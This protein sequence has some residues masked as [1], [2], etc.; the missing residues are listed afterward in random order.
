MSREEFKKQFALKDL[1]IV[2]TI[3]MSIGG[4]TAMTSYRLEAV[5]TKMPSI[6]HLKEDAIRNE[7]KIAEIQSL[8]EEVIGLNMNLDDWSE[9][10]KVFVQNIIKQ[11][12]ETSKRIVVMEAKCSDKVDKREVNKWIVKMKRENVTMHIP[13]LGET[14]E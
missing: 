1:V 5:E 11:T 8:K 6:Q 13:D 12:A 4:F 14:L 7:S 3:I 10:Q 2:A 9:E